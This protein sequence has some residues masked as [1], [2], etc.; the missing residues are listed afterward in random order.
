MNPENNQPGKLQ[1]IE[2]VLTVL[3][4]MARQYH[5][6]QPAENL[7][8]HELD[9]CNTSRALETF[10]QEQLQHTQTRT[11]QQKHVNY[12][13]TGYAAKNYKAE[14]SIQIASPSNGLAPKIQAMQNQL[15]EAIKR[16]NLS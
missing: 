3:T 11:P 9:V 2:T 10:F 4:N 13:P 5:A 8:E 7:T 6:R 14:N 12:L 15:A 16:E 1:T